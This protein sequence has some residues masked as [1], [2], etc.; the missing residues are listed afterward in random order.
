MCDLEGKKEL[1][2]IGKE[3][4]QTRGARPRQVAPDAEAPRVVTTGGKIEAVA[5]EAAGELPSGVDLET[6]EAVVICSTGC[7]VSVT[8]HLNPLLTARDRAA[9]VDTLA[10]TVIPPDGQSM[11][12]VLA[13]MARFLPIDEIEDR[14][15]CFGF[16]F[17]KQFGKGAG[18]VAWGGRSQ[19]DRVYFSIQ[20]KGCS[21]VSDWPSLAAWLEAH[22][23]KIKRADVAYDDFAGELV[24]ISWGISQ[25][26]AGGFMA[27]G[28]S[29]RHEMFGDVLDGEKSTRGRTLGIGSRTSGKYCRIYEKGKQLG[30]PSSSWARVEVEW[31]GKDRL[32]PYELLRR[33]GPYLAGAYPCLAQLN[34]DQARIRTVKNAEKISVEAATEHHRRQSGRMVNYL[35]HHLGGDYAA[36]VETLRR[37]GMPPRLETFAKHPAVDDEPLTA[38]E[39]ASE[40]PKAEG[41]A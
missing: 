8:R 17:S 31:R 40:E 12:W 23:A 13:Q 4:A 14:R 34:C 19:R 27:G 41:E 9:I 10:F 11:R 6:G 32:V 37:D 21:L 38:A 26:K 22:R 25:Y 24:S 35:L 39:P 29:P 18:L 1:E 2:G 20:G 7:G 15:G 16:K 28:R 5:S 30:D 3:L 33:P 36:V